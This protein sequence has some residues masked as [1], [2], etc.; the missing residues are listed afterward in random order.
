M[1]TSKICTRCGQSKQLDEYTKDKRLSDGRTSRCKSCTYK[2]ADE[3]SKRLNGMSKTDNNTSIHQTKKYKLKISKLKAIELHR[4]ISEI[5][6]EMKTKDR[7]ATES[8]SQKRV[9][10]QIAFEN[11]V[12]PTHRGCYKCGEI[13]SISEFYI[14]K[15]SIDGHDRRCKKCDS[16]KGKQYMK[17]PIV[18]SRVKE[19][20]SS[21]YYSNM[22]DPVIGAEMRASFAESRHKRRATLQSRGHITAKEFRDV[23]S[24]SKGVCYW[25]NKKIN[26]V[27]HYDHYSPLDDGGSNTIDNIV[28]SCAYCNLSKG[29]KSPELFANERGRLL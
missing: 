11:T 25:C 1:E 2:R 9:E 23:L 18:K 20:S 10:K 16:T 28:V 5:K 21:R 22:R 7:D 27:H 17:D 4:R 15:R 14:S 26:G 8:D 12:M 13:K 24:K 19:S 6:R 29:R 3:S